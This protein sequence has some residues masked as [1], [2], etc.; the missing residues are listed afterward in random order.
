MTNSKHSR[1]EMVIQKEGKNMRYRK[2]SNSESQCQR[3]VNSAR[4]SPNFPSL[5]NRSSPIKMSSPVN[6][7]RPS[8]DSHSQSPS[9]TLGIYYAGARFSEPPAPQS[10]PQPPSSWTFFNTCP[11]SPAIETNTLRMLLK[12]GA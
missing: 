4:E 1:V 5:S 9:P 11:P 10:L 3:P 7:N 8:R 2:S 12:V 6:I